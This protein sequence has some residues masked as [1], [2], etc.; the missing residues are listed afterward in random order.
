MLWFGFVHMPS[1]RLKMAHLPG[2]FGILAKCC[3]LAGPKFFLLAEGL[4]LREAYQEL[5]EFVAPTYISFPIRYGYW[6]SP[7]TEVHFFIYRK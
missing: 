6:E 5:L 7:V 1:P 3:S 2:T 4:S